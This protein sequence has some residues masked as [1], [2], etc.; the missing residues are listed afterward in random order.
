M[1]RLFYIIVFLNLV[2]ICIAKTLSL[3]EYVQKANEYLT[4]E[5]YEKA[6]T[7]MEQAVKEYPN[8]SRA[9]AEL[10]DFISKKAK[11]Y[12]DMLF[13]LPQ[14]FPV[15]DKAISLDP[16][17]LEARFSRGTWGVYVPQAMGQLDKA[18]SDLEY[19]VEVLQKTTDQ[20]KKARL[21]EA[22]SYLADGYRKQ[23]E[24]EKAKKTYNKI[25]ENNPEADAAAYA[26]TNIDRIIEFE[27]W[28]EQEA[29]SKEPDSPEIVAIKKE[30]KQ[31]PENATLLIKLANEYF[32]IQD[33]E[34]ARTAL[35]Q[36]ISIE[37][38]NLQAHK[39]LSLTIG[40]LLKQGYTPEVILDRNFLTDIILELIQV[41]DKGV[42]IAPEDIEM[43]LIRGSACAELPPFVEQTE[44]AID[45]LQMVLESDI[46]DDMKAQ[47]LYGLGLAYQKKTIANWNKVVSGYSNTEVLD[48]VF[49]ELNPGLKDID[50]T[51]Y[52]TPVVIIDFILGFKD[53]LPPQT[54]VW[55]EDKDGNFVKTIY[56]SAFTGYAKARGRIPQW[57]KTSDFID[58]DGVTAASI[59][60]G[61][62]IYVWDL[63]DISG[64]KVKNGEYVVKV[65]TV[66][67]P[68]MQYQCVES[69]LT[70]GKKADSRV[71]EEGKIIPY[72]KVKYLP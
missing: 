15:W 58:V 56:I 55:V 30:L 68:S 4:A 36:A 23:Q 40:N 18:V 48:F 25:I 28:L 22:Y 63:K 65:E 19:V 9:Y 52:K 54:A 51:Q 69:P 17:N 1:K 47:A 33:Y 46:S 8:S 62:H 7:T 44:K 61:H 42:R 71:I 5:D 31:N 27:K 67:W 34:E 50:I 64:K 14:A 43:R 45:D 12:I 66:F 2:N 26:R 70:L 57:T 39:L 10:G 72:L 24:F 35:R 38:S 59:N 53:E 41:T 29:K 37:P 20:D 21:I 6:V 16:D 11:R 32:N 60:Q 13:V 49:D 3:E